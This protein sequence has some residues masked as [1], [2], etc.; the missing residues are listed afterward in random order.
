MSKA[1]LFINGKKPKQIPDNLRSYSLISCTD[2]AYSRYVK[3]LPLT[4]DC[5]SGDLDS[6]IWN[7]I[8]PGIQII[9]TPDQNKTD[10]HKA[11]KLLLEK[12]ITEIDVLGAAGR[13]SDHFIGNLAT[14]LFFKNQLKITFYDNGSRFFFS[15]KRTELHQVKGKIISLIPFFEAE[16]IYTQGLKYPLNNEPLRFPERIGTRNIADQDSVIITYSKGELLIYTGK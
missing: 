7:E 4:V 6:I 3:K 8:P 2:G 16:G 13:E 9:H 12:G 5:I 14:A 15:D 1:L 10:F 11:L